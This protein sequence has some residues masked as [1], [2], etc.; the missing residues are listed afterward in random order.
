M[1]FMGNMPMPPMQQQQGPHVSSEVHPSHTLQRPFHALTSQPMTTPSGSFH[2]DVSQQPPTSAP[3]AI[4]NFDANPTLPIQQG[5]TPQQ[6]FVAPEMIHPTS[7]AATSH[8]QEFQLALNPS[9]AAPMSAPFNTMSAPSNYH[10]GD[11]DR[12][13][14]FRGA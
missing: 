13:N 11:P 1:N 10:Q 14:G 5:V 12:Y 8:S 3:H 7:S 6:S 4:G 9:S 2:V